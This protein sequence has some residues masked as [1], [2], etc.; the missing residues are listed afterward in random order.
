MKEINKLN[1]IDFGFIMEYVKGK[2]KADIQWLKELAE[3]PVPPDKNGKERKISFI[4][5]RKEFAIK[6]FPDFA[7]K[8]K[9]KKPTMWEQIADL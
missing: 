6:Y 8:E 3:M 7:P 1:D 2:G 9:V 4:E 5:L